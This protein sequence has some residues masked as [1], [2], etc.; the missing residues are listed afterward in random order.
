MNRAFFSDRAHFTSGV[1]DQAPL[2]ARFPQGV[3]DFSR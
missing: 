1:E 2:E 3:V